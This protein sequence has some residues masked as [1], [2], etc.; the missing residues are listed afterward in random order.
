V[1]AS[2]KGSLEH[3]VQIAVAGVPV[4]VS[5]DSDEICVSAAQRHVG[6]PIENGNA[7]HVDVRVVKKRSA[8]TQRVSWTYPDKNHVVV[9]SPWLSASL[10]LA[11]AS[12][13]IECEAAHVA[14]PEAQRIIFEG[15]M[16]SLIRRKDRHPVHAAVIQRG[17]LALLLAGGSGVGKS[18][19]TYV[20]HRAGLTVLAD[21]SARIQLHPSLRIWG[22]GSPARIHLLEH[23]RD[24]FAELKELRGDWVS[25]TGTLKLTVPLRANTKP[26]QPYARRARVCLLDRGNGAVQLKRVVPREIRDAIMNASE[27]HSD[28]EPEQRARVADAL[29]AAGGWRLTLSSHPGDAL[30]RVHEMLDAMERE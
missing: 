3:S 2:K 11:A 13:R 19:L 22:D 12:A 17:D 28:R 26:W 23:A 24:S 15:V 14:A 16:Y 9:E 30:P 29:S 1:T 27:A 4:C 20:A 8:A 5:S 10:D 7:C 25:P 18:T 21:D 6:V